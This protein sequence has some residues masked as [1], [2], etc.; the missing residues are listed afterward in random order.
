VLS[1]KF[2]H[3][4]DD[5]KD[6]L[7]VVSRQKKIQSQLVEKDYWIMHCLFGLKTL[8]LKFELKGGTSLSKGY[9]IIERFSEDID[10]RIEPPEEM[11]VKTGKN[12]TKEA[13]I[14]SRRKFYDWLAEERIVVPGIIQAER[15]TEFDNEKLTS[16][17]IRLI[18]KSHFTTLEGVNPW[19]LLE[20]GFDETTPNHPINISSWAYDKAIESAIKTT[21]NRAIGIECYD[22]GFTFVEKLQTVSTKFRRQ[23]KAGNSENFPKKFLRHYSDIYCLLED[24]RVQ[25]FIGTREYEERKRVRFP[26]ADNTNICENEA[27]LL[28]DPEVRKLYEQEYEKTRNLYYGDVVPFAA[29]LER[30]KLNIEKL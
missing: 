13:H 26:Q 10:V 30:I 6:L 11:E 17:G 2:L 18:Y 19:V 12:H 28:S 15:D 21:D 22:P 23:Q 5:F 7:L 20:V 3:E 14:A 1:E 24:Q 8:G 27:F 25:E 16:A 9:G 4:L 29:I